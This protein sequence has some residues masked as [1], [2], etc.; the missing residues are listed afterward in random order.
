M[1]D[2]KQVRRDTSNIYV[3]PKPLMN[4]VTAVVMQFTTKGSKEVTLKARG[5]FTARAIDIAQVARERFLKDMNIQ[6]G[7]INICSESFKNKEGKD[8]RVSSLSIKLI[9]K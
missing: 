2:E 1:G 7:A 9:K 5:K 8:I 3:G 6:L 4:Y